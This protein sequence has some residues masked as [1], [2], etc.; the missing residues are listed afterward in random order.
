MVDD[1]IEPPLKTSIIDIHTITD[2]N[3]TII[4]S[5]ITLLFGFNTSKVVAAKD[6]GIYEL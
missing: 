5:T 1:G 2:N 3:C 6:C 4:I